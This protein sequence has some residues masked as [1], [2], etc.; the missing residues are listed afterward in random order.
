[1]NAGGIAEA[2]V[3][4]TTIHN[5]SDGLKDPAGAVR[6]C[7]VQEAGRSGAR[8]APDLHRFRS[9]TDPQKD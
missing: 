8:L 3:R 6:V 1:V 7:P 2:T 4:F 5:D 9:R